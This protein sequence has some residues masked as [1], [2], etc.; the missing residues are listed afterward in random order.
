MPCCSVCQGILV[1]DIQVFPYRFNGNNKFDLLLRLGN[2]ARASSHWFWQ[3]IRR[4]VS[5]GKLYNKPFKRNSVRKREDTLY[6]SHLICSLFP[7]GSNGM[8]WRSPQMKTLNPIHSS[9]PTFQNCS[10]SH[11][12]CYRTRINFIS[13]LAPFC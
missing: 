6:V 2:A 1:S 9:F 5:F 12:K 8:N 3:L 4:K 10:C 11:R 13:F 7:L